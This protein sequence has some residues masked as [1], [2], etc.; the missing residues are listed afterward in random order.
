M[1]EKRNSRRN[2]LLKIG[3]VL[4]LGFLVIILAG[5]TWDYSGKPSFCTT[6]HSMESVIVSHSSSSHAEVSCTDCHLGVGFAPN[7][8]VK[9]TADAS[10][11]VKTIT[12]KYEK[13]IRVQ[14]NLPVKASC[15]SCHYTKSFKEESTRVI[16]RYGMDPDNTKVTTAVLFKVGDGSRGEGIH[17]HVENRINYGKDESGRIVY[18]EVDKENGEKGVYRLADG[19]DPVS[20][21]DMDCVD[22]HNR[23][24]HNIEPPGDLADQYFHAGKLDP[25]L[26][27]LK[28]EVVGL[29]EKT[30]GGDL[31]VDPEIFESIVSFYEDKYPEIY[32][33]KQ[34]EINQLP[35]IIQEMTGQIVYPEMLA[36]WATYPDKLSHEG[37]FQCHTQEFYLDTTVAS[38]GVPETIPSDC[39]LCHSNPVI[40]EGGGKT[41]VV[42]LK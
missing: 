23:V 40:V 2:L 14:D 9:K 21:K 24:A 18:M 31:S 28:R 11:I 6:C 3:G 19:G 25:S 20:Y 15:E 36:T 35:Q 38:S 12:G 27:Y 29:L 30:N 13:P 33:E 5:T 26:P 17:W 32:Q 1:T 41:L 37:C 10:Q 8:L 7:M 22:C 39:Q 16:E 4:V 34:N 42:D